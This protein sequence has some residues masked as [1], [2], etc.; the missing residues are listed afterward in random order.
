M[1]ILFIALLAITMTT[2]LAPL[3]VA[4]RFDPQAR[5]E[6]ERVYSAWRK[7]LIEKD[8]Q[9]WKLHTAKFR[10]LQVQNEI[11]SQKQP[12]PLAL[13]QIPMA[14]PSL[15]TLK[16]VDLKVKGDIA[17]ACY[18]GKIDF[19]LGL[20][21]LPENLLLLKYAREDGV[22]KYN[23]AQFFNLE[24]QDSLR[25]SLRTGNYGFLKRPEFDLPD[26]V[27]AIPA[28]VPKP[29]YVGQVHLLAIGCTAK[30][31]TGGRVALQAADTRKSELIIGGLKAGAN[32]VK[33]EVTPLE[34]VEDD[35][36]QLGVVIYAYPDDR[37]KR[38]VEVFRH[39]PATIEAS[40]EERFLV[41]AS[42]LK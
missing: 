1:R 33:V 21:D 13:F 41:D 30:I 3:A 5:R 32:M 18:F 22:W 12:F 9:S 36:I 14:P 34:G 25:A 2:S 23:N 7:A 29:D 40:H 38:P 16:F 24:G 37:T 19:N 42:R 20:P 6:V 28:A 15:V 27:P 35:E 11:V 10:Q 8:F 39:E 31:S 17:H 26:E 4:Q